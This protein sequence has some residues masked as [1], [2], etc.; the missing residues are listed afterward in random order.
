MDSGPLTHGL[1]PGEQPRNAGPFFQTLFSILILL[2][3][4]RPAGD[5]GGAL[6]FF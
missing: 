5:P 1:M 6:T 2:L 4:L 3:I